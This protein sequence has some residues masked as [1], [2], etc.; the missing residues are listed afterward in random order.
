M[1]AERELSRKCLQL[2]DRENDRLNELEMRKALAVKKALMN[3]KEKGDDLK[4]RF[5]AKC[6]TRIAQRWD[7]RR[8]VYVESCHCMGGY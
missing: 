7:V 2:I 8:R 4:P 6:G 1:M 3:I 5:C